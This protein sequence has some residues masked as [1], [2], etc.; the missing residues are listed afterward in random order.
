MKFKVLLSAF[1]LF[2]A[3]FFSFE[4]N[5]QTPNQQLQIGNAT[6]LQYA[7]TVIAYD[8]NCNAFPITRTINPGATLTLPALPS[9]TYAHAT[10]YTC[11]AYPGGAIGL[12]NCNTSP[13]FATYPVC[14]GTHT[15]SWQS[16]NA[17]IVIQ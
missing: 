6:N 9:Y 12:G 10:L 4:A 14:G 3:L 2:G 13:P 17:F 1:A 5:A 8:A 16:G 7:V 15:A 11:G